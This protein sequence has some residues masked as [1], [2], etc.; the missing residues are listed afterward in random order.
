MS[1]WLITE[2]IV[3]PAKSG[4]VIRTQILHNRKHKHCQSLLPFWIKL[5]DLKEALYICVCVFFKENR[6]YVIF[7]SMFWV[8]IF[9]EYFARTKSCQRGREEKNKSKI[10]SSLNP[11]QTRRGTRL[12]TVAWMLM[13]TEL[14]SGNLLNALQGKL[15]G[16]FPNSLFPLVIILKSAPRDGPVPS[17]IH[18]GQMH[19]DSLLKFLEELRLI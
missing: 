2:I 10:F 4:L 5:G 1:C 18:I 7:L 8:I 3:S 11:E 16:H 13:N 15:G 9:M 6:L 17:Q 12:Q 14:Y 19:Y